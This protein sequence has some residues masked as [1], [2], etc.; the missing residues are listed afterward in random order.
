MEPSLLGGSRLSLLLPVPAQL[1][2]LNPVSA[3]SVQKTEM[4]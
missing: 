2:L 3:L 1:K 4:I